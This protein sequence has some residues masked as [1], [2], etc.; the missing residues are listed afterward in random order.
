MLFLD[1]RSLDY[2]LEPLPAGADLLVVDSGTPRALAHTAYN[3]RREEAE[4]AAR[5]LGAASLRDVTDPALCAGLPAPLDRRARHVVTE[6]ARV[7]EGRHADAARFGALM[8]ASHASLATA[9]EVSTPALDALAAALQAQ[10][11]AFGA[12]LTGAGFGGA[13]VALVAA[14]AGAGVATGAL[15]AYGATGY[16]GGRVLVG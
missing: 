1:T 11:G 10:P 5:L 12:R 6:N 4:Q 15:A 7:L 9:Y 13:C 8:N 3:R 14:G 16:A 2:A